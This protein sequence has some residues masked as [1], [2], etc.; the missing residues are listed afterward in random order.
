MSFWNM[1]QL[2]L[3]IRTMQSSFG[4]TI[5]I[6]SG[7]M[8]GTFVITIHFW[9]PIFWSLEENRHCQNY[10]TMRLDFAKN[11]LEIFSPMKFKLIGLKSLICKYSI[12]MA[13]CS[14]TCRGPWS[15]WVPPTI[16]TL[17]FMGNVVGV[18]WSEFLCQQNISIS[19]QSNLHAWNT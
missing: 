1:L 15:W 13:S 16:S 4:M 19:S 18:D 10:I 6:D 7:F 2:M 3:Q 8:K 12:H 14:A 11:M 17:R 5:V 9:N